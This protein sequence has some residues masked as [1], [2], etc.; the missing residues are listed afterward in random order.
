MDHFGD[1]AFIL[2]SIVLSSYFEMCRR[3]GRLSVVFVSRVSPCA[4]KRGYLHSLDLPSLFLG[5]GGAKLL[6]APPLTKGA[7]GF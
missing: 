2:N 1:T 5:E 3:R 4:C 6:Y 7:P